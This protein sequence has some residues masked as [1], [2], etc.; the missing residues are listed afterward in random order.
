MRSAWQPI[1]ARG[2]RYRL[3]MAQE[4]DASSGHAIARL[5]D[6]SEDAMRNLVALPL[7]MLAGA[8][9]IFEAL[10]RTAADAVSEGEP[11]DER[12]V[13][14]ERRMDSLE[15]QAT[16]LREGSGA[17]SVTRKR[18]PTGADTAAEQRGA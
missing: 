7:R 6:S 9:G 1:L 8:L 16:G 4:A 2:T 3:G 12:V 11:I 17:T 14:L 18:T 10:L 5:A 13:D 15:E